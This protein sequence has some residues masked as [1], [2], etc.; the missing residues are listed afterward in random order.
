MSFVSFDIVRV[1]VFVDL[2]CIC[3][4]FAWVDI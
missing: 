3:D 1:D 2:V 4:C